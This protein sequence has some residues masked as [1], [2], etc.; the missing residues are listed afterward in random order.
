MTSPNPK[1]VASPTAPAAGGEA[2]TKSNTVD[3]AGG[4]FRALY[5]GSTGDVAVVTTSG[6]V[7]TFVGVPTGAILPVYGIRVNSTGTSAASIV[8]LW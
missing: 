4:P 3:V 2:V 1:F 8:A 5:I 7:L 6:T